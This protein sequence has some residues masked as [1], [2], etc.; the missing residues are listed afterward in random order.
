MPPVTVMSITPLLAATQEGL[1]RIADTA[2]G[3]GWLSTVVR[4]ST[5]PRLSVTVTK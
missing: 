2:R 3:L 1:V 5:H 4:V